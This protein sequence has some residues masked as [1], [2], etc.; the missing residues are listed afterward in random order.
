MEFNGKFMCVDGSLV[1]VDI[2]E[3]FWGELGING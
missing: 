1:S 2:G 3:I